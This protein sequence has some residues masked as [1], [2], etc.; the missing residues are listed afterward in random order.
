MG[1]DMNELYRPLLNSICFLILS[2]SVNS[3][4]AV[5]YV[6]TSGS[7]SSG[8]TQAA[9]WRT[10][11]YATQKSLQPG[12][13]VVLA[14]G[15]YVEPELSIRSSGQLGN[16]IV[17]RALNPRRA[18]IQSTSCNMGLNIYASHVTIDGLR[19]QAAPNIACS[20][21]G[22]RTMVQAW[23]CGTQPKIYANSNS[24]C[25]HFTFRNS[26]IDYSTTMNVGL[27]SR[28]DF[29]IVENSSIYCIESFNNN[30]MI[31]R[32]NVVYSK[33]NGY[34]GAGIGS[35]GG[36]RNIQI[37]NNLVYQQ[38]N[39]LGIVLGG[40]SGNQWIYDPSTGYE[41]Y[42][43]VAYN[44][45][46]I[47]QD[48]TWERELLGMYGT[49]DSALYNNIVIGGGFYFGPGGVTGYPQPKPHNPI[50]KNNIFVCRAGSAVGGWYDI[51]Y[52]SG[53]RIIDNNNF[54]NCSNVPSQSHPIVGDPLFAN[55]SALDFHLQEQSPA[56][57]TGALTSMVG[58]NGEIIDISRDRDGIQRSVPYSLGIYAGVNSTATS[59]PAPA[60]SPEPSSTVTPLTAD[61][62][63][64]SVVFYANADGSYVFTTLTVKTSVA[65]A[66]VEI[67][68][69][70]F[71][72]FSTKSAEPY[73]FTWCV[74]CFGANEPLPRKSILKATATGKDGQ[75]V[76]DSVEVSVFPYTSRTPA[77]TEIIGTK[78]DSSKFLSDGGFAYVLSL[79]SGTKA[80]NSS[81][82]SQ[83]V[84]RLYENGREIGPAHSI[85]ADIRN[86]GRGRFSHWS[87][88]DGSR[89]VIR[90]A[91]SDNTDPRTNGRVYSYVITSIAAANTD[92]KFNL[93]YQNGTLI[94][95]NATILSLDFRNIRSV[96]L[97]WYGREENGIGI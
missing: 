39:D 17:F 43:C 20:G 29:S 36:T 47:G 10:L 82:P 73:V 86:L 31:V 66:K 4:G 26:Q 22:A 13:S 5:Y 23:D 76:S 55:A 71:A 11:K 91:A 84:L 92:L 65:V 7:D 21:Y 8:G 63:L 88:T 54:F 30:G 77:S 96:S 46:V 79:T 78:L 28:Q 32:N 27:K 37:Y 14:D 25:S 44:N 94:T 45:V 53:A 60:P 67:S 1:W 33:V 49:K 40:T 89:E 68:R 51:N 2:F 42:N 16:P 56:L 62:T 41:C 95:R 35:K 85:R 69:D 50:I 6:S 97:R 75:V 24:L 64:P 9:P 12:D 48:G 18:I 70:G 80:D 52:Y 83:S 59:T 57:G 81:F 15:T 3:W 19:F 34:Q 38:G 72:P 58:Y 61:L 90:F 87:R 93:A 74:T